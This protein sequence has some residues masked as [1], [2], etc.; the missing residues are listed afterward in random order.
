VIVFNHLLHPVGVRDHRDQL[1][2]DVGERLGGRLERIAAEL[3]D[4][5]F[6]L[7]RR[8]AGVEADDCSNQDVRPVTAVLPWSHNAS[9]KT[10]V[11]ASGTDGKNQYLA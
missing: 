4:L 3:V 5:R 8:A 7:P 1:G 10:T 2:I 9:D 11:D 6:N